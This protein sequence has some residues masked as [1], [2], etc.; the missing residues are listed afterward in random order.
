MKRAFNNTSPLRTQSAGVMK[1]FELEEKRLKNLLKTEKLWGKEDKEGEK[2]RCRKHLGTPSEKYSSRSLL[3]KRPLGTFLQ[4]KVSF[5]AL[6]LYVPFLSGMRLLRLQ[7]WLKVTAHLEKRAAPEASLSWAPSAGIGRVYKDACSSL[8][9]SVVSE[10]LVS[11]GSWF[12][13]CS[14]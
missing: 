7:S 8:L 11:F 4:A 2:V 5:I 1:Y 9:F 14:P 10:W 3:T 12:C 13:F 6:N